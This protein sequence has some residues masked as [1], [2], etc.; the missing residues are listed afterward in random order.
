[1]I[2]LLLTT[3]SLLLANN[4]AHKPTQQLTYYF[5][6]LIKT[7][8]KD[9]MRHNVVCCDQGYVLPRDTSTYPRD[10]TI[11]AQTKNP[12]TSWFTI[13]ENWSQQNTWILPPY[14]K[15]DNSKDK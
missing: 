14:K 1:M 12:S 6:H 3:L 15:K 11:E 13:P 10:A 9:T 2:S 8:M 4:G 5:S 7:T